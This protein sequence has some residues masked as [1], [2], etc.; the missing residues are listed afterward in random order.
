MERWWQRQLRLWNL[1]WDQPF[2]LT[3]NDCPVEIVFR[4][5]LALFAKL[6]VF[7]L[8]LL[9]TNCACCCASRHLFGSSFEKRQK[10]KKASQVWCFNFI[11]WNFVGDNFCSVWGFRLSRL[12]CCCDCVCELSNSISF[13]FFAL[14]WLDSKSPKKQQQQQQQQDQEIN[15]NHLLFVC[16]SFFFFVDQVAITLGLPAFSVALIQHFRTSKIDKWVKWRSL[17]IG[18]YAAFPVFWPSFFLIPTNFDISPHP[19]SPIKPQQE[20]EVLAPWLDQKRRV[21]VC[22]LFLDFSKKALSLSLLLCSQKVVWLKA[23]WF[24]WSFVEL[25]CL[26]WS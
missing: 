20:E 1:K 16:V 8:I 15:R 7:I 14:P 6:G 18:Y 12:C 10:K 13:L 2:M 21:Q 24:V 25:C 22:T 23:L 4:E 11:F 19:L 3:R 26:I 17:Y 5:A 9:A